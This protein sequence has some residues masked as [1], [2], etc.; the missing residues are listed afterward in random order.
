M[1]QQ[2]HLSCGEVNGELLKTDLHKSWTTS[3]P[4]TLGLMQA[5]RI[6]FCIR[7]PGSTAQCVAASIEADPEEVSALI[8]L[9]PCII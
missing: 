2:A 4:K 8:G 5:K 1:I 7:C 3:L 9:P 6:R